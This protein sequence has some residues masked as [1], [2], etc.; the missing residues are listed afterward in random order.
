MDQL[1]KTLMITYECINC[2]RLI[3]H[4]PFIIEYIDEYNDMCF[5]YYCKNC[6]KYLFLTSST[7][8]TPFLTS[9]SSP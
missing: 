5:E 9:T 1:L 8:W 7:L 2:Q 3:D 6:S 4:K